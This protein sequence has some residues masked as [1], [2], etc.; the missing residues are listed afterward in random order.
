MLTEGSNSPSSPYTAAARNKQLHESYLERGQQSNFNATNFLT[1]QNSKR[2]EDRMEYNFGN[3]STLVSLATND[4]AE[5]L[6]RVNQKRRKRKVYRVVRVSC[7]NC[8]QSKQACDEFR[9][10]A[11]CIRLGLEEMCVDAPSSRPRPLSSQIPSP[12]DKLFSKVQIHKELDRLSSR[13]S[14]VS[15]IDSGKDNSCSNE[16]RNN[17]AEISHLLSPLFSNGEHLKDSFISRYYSGERSQFT[18]NYEET[19]RNIETENFEDTVLEAIYEL[20]KMILLWDQDLQSRERQSSTKEEFEDMAKSHALFSYVLKVL[21]K[22]LQLWGVE[23]FSDSGKRVLT[24]LQSLQNLSSAKPDSISR[25]RSY[26]P[27]RK[28]KL[29]ADQQHEFLANI[30][31]ACL[32][33][34]LRVDDSFHTVDFANKEACDLFAASEEDLSILIGCRETLPIVMGGIDWIR[35][36]MFLLRLLTENTL[37]RAE[38]YNLVTFDG[39]LYK[40]NVSCSVVLG[41]NWEPDSYIFLL[42]SAERLGKD[43]F[44]GSF[45]YRVVSH[46]KS[47]RLQNNMDELAR[48][49][50]RGQESFASGKT[51]EGCFSV[52]SSAVLHM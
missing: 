44:A 13:G 30:P 28:V 24:I 18:T 49:S 46:V 37:K 17:A 7:V 15:S 39:S 45:L 19:T 42:Q 5:E 50:Q 36:P 35:K 31:M 38:E 16:V 26:L 40:C 6:P 33:M 10:C 29:T 47:K 23:S 20:S 3:S 51:P 48:A 25:I 21:K 2:E 9:P 41:D 52:S 22:F 34:S 27:V 12:N 4:T 11:R 32:K 1:A 14:M 8:R 43:P